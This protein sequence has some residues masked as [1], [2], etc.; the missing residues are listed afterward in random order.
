[1]YSIETDRLATF[2][3]LPY[4]QDVNTTSIKSFM[5]ITLNK[6]KYILLYLE[7]IEIYVHF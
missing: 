3:Y 5:V 1:V 4:L 6:F 7:I 2:H